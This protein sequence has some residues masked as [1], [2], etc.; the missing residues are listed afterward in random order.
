MIGALV[1]AVLMLATAFAFIGAHTKRV[2]ARERAVSNLRVLRE[3][4]NMSIYRPHY[5]VDPRRRTYRKDQP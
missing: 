5:I 4:K 1:V 2:M 3:Y